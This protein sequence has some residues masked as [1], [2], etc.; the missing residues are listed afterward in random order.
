MPFKHLCLLESGL[1]PSS[2]PIWR[3]IRREVGSRHLGLAI[4]VAREGLDSLLSS[5]RPND[6]THVP[7][8]HGSPVDTRAVRDLARTRT[9]RTTMT[10]METKSPGESEHGA[11]S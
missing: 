10:T 8:G 3:A 6:K 9:T 4:E 2:R 7:M 1:R 11:G 5:D